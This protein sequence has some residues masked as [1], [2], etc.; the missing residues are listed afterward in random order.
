MV[1]TRFGIFLLSGWLVSGCVSL[2]SGG[3]RLFSLKPDAVATVSN[4]EVEEEL[5]AESEDTEELDA[6]LQALTYRSPS[7]QL[8]LPQRSNRLS[9]ALQNALGLQGTPYRRG[10]TSENGLDCSGLVYVSY[11]AAGIKLPRTSQEQFHAT[12]RVER[13]E[14]RPGDLVFFRTG[15][16]RGRQVDHVGIYLG[17]DKFLHAPRRGKPVSVASLEHGYWRQRFVGAG[18]A[19]DEAPPSLSLAELLAM[20]E[21]EPAAQNVAAATPSVLTPNDPAGTS[22][23]SSQPGANRAASSTL[24]RRDKARRSTQTKLTAAASRSQPK[25]AVRSARAP[26]TQPAAATRSQPKAA[27]TQTSPKATAQRS[28]LPRTSNPPASIQRGHKTTVA[29]GQ[30]AMG[31]AGVQGTPRPPSTAAQKAK[32]PPAAA[33][34]LTSPKPNARADK[35]SPPP[36]S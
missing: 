1:W 18:R 35:S 6:W 25:A 8:E 4:E 28:N 20:A 24:P 34:K 22:A 19:S 29:Q 17:N 16:I 12:R 10:G 26:Q 7:Y 32:S 13:H 9:Q 15:R 33:G 30:S 21:P 3:F 31:R 11:G 5:D 2:G 23:T 27:A 14:L 36:A